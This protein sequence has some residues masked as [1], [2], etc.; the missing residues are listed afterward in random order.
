MPSNGWEY[1]ILKSRTIWTDSADKHTSEGHL[2]LNCRRPELILHAMRMVHDPFFTSESTQCT[3]L[4][5]RSGW[6][7]LRGKEISTLTFLCREFICRYK[8]WPLWRSLE[9]SWRT[10]TLAVTTKQWSD[11]VTLLSL[12][13]RL[14]VWNIAMIVHASNGCYTFKSKIKYRSEFCE[15]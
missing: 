5:V 4:E 7:T 1:Q 11:R 14:P 13:L 8:K 12:S 3:G 10:S 6:E 2:V 9:L 15:F